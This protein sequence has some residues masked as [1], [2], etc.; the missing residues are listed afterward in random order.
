M[1]LL[2]LLGLTAIVHAEPVVTLPLD[3]Y[4][5]PGK[6]FPVKIESDREVTVEVKADAV[7]SRG[8]GRSLV[9]PAMSL[10]RVASVVTVIVD[11]KPTELPIHP[12]E[13]DQPLW[14]QLG[15]APL[16]RPAAG[17]FVVVNTPGNVRGL[18]MAFES[19]DFIQ[20]APEQLQYLRD[21]P[22]MLSGTTFV[23]EG[24]L[25]EPEIRGPMTSLE[26][27][28]AYTVPV[29][30]G[31]D[32]PTRQATWLLLALF[33]I[34]VL[35]LAL[36]RWR[37]SWAAIGV[38]SLAAVAFGAYRWNTTSPVTTATTEVT[39][40]GRG[41]FYQDRWTFL[42]SL[43]DTT[44]SFYVVNTEIVRPIFAGQAEQLGMVI[45]PTV[46]GW[47]YQFHLSRGSSVAM[48]GR[49]VVQ[50]DLLP[51]DDLPGGEFRNLMR[52]SYQRAGETLIRASTGGDEHHEAYWVVRKPA[53]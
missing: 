43:E 24:N 25:I 46:G 21:T 9:L 3:G 31:R 28:R 30:P 53:R 32:L 5:R 17:K 39:Y 8:H 40:P 14:L 11:G 7:S 23:E 36:W 35:A 19:A 26:D 20:I 37:F 38:C 10:S 15:D 49:G 34:G 50:L 27:P 48:M 33:S 13:T 16:D 52:M 6:F 29:V 47:Q 12:L 41:Y 22:L 44:Q 4:Y 1:W 45:E 18:S 51:A 2:V 42:S